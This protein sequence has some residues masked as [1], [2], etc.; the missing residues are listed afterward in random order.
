MDLSKVLRGVEAGE[1]FDNETMTKLM[2]YRLI[3]Q[4]HELT[5]LGRI[6][7]RDAEMAWL[8]WSMR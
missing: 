1:F 2:R 8:G 3:T 7:L 5:D 6:V 4:K